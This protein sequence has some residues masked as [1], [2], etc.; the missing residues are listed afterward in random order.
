MKKG[1]TLI[2]VLV[3]V[4]ILAGVIIAAATIEAKQVKNS[5]G[6]KQQLE[7]LGIAQKNLNLSKQIFDN[8]IL[9]TTTIF[10]TDET[11]IYSLND[12]GNPSLVDRETLASNQKCE[13]NGIKGKWFVVNEGEVNERKYC[14]KIEINNP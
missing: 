2:E 4:V 12:T 10:P 13:I 11:K 9:N 7:A 6:N 8:D 1:F 14:V 3:A 5:A